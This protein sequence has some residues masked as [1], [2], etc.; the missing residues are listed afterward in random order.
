MIKDM[1]KINNNGNHIDEEVKNLIEKYHY[2]KSIR[3]QKQKYVFK[4]VEKSTD[5]LV[6]VAIYGQPMSRRQDSDVIEL[7]R[8]CLVD[9]TPRNTESWFIARTLKWLGINTKYS[10]V[11]SFAD[12]NYNHFGTIYK[13]SNFEYDGLESNKNPRMIEY[14]GKKYHIRQYYAKNKSGD[15]CKH[16]IKLQAK[17][18]IGEAKIIKQSRKHKYTYYLR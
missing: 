11:I 9:D 8:L 16:A 6:G 14:N 1:Y 15:Y 4:L 7:R 5:K 13:A 3:S 12:P 2:S 18:K 17:V 10:R